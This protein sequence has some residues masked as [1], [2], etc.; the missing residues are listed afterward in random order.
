MKTCYVF[1]INTSYAEIPKLSLPIVAKNNFLYA[2]Q[3]GGEVNF[4]TGF[5]VNFRDTSKGD[6]SYEEVGTKG[7]TKR[8]DC[9]AVG[10]PQSRGKG[11]DEAGVNGERPA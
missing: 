1:H 9:H 5:W 7:A 3:K 11:R 2:G 8:S 10:P 4:Y 6:V